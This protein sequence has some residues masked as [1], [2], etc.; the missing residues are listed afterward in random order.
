MN[1][2]EEQKKRFDEIRLTGIGGSDAP[3]VAG[4][5]PWQSPYQLWLRKRGEL[6]PPEL[7]EPMRWGTLLEP[8]VAQEYSRRTGFAVHK[9]VELLRS[10]AYPWMI[11]HVDGIALDGERL[12][13]CKTARFARG[14]GE[15]GSDEIPLHY[16]VQ[17]HH[18]MIVAEARVCDIAVLIGGS[19]FRIYTVEA[20]RDIAEILI[21]QQRDFW[22]RVREGEPPDPIN[23]EDAVRRWGAFDVAGKVEAGDVERAAVYELRSCKTIRDDLA[24]REDAA[25]TIVLRA[26]ADQGDALVDDLGNVLATWRLDNGRKAYSVAAREPARRFLLK[27]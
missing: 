1:D 22:N 23:V 9:P 20:D 12:L 5:D 15:P 27:D 16:A 26:L 2:D 17:V 8:L 21:A 7:N 13:E 4:L 3:A 18:Y 24:Q 11:G 25:K 14:W 6:E 19:D 10:E